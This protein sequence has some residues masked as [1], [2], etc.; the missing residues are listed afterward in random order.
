MKLHDLTRD[1]CRCGIDL[2][3]RTSLLLTSAE[4]A[5]VAGPDPSSDDKL[6]LECG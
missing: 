3:S 2:V 5:V 6:V 4:S 1:P